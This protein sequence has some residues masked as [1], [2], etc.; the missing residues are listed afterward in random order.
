MRREFPHKL[1]VQHIGAAAR[2]REASGLRSR[3]KRRFSPAVDEVMSA[4]IAAA[5]LANRQGLQKLGL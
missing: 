2:Q 5:I 1:P 3:Q 4:K